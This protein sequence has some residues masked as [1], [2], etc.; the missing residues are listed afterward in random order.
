MKGRSRPPLSSW[1]QLVGRVSTTRSTPILCPTSVKCLPSPS[2]RYSVF[3]VAAFLANSIAAPAADLSMTPIYQGRLPAVAAADWALADRWTVYSSVEANAGGS[4]PP[5]A[6][7]NS[8][9]RNA[10]STGAGAIL[11][12][13]WGLKGEYVYVNFL[14][15][16]VAEPPGGTSTLSKTNGPPS[17]RTLKIGGNY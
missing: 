14:K 13:H 11:L 1:I 8:S 5:Q 7:R 15:A 2:L 12:T 17:G 3:G 6:D 4:L 9:H 10:W 16:G